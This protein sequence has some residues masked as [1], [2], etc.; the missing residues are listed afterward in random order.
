VNFQGCL[1]RSYPGQFQTLLDTGNG[2]YRRIKG[3]DF[4]PPLG[5]FKQELT[6]ELIRQ[7]VLQEESSALNFLRTGY[8]T[9]TWW[10]DE[11]PDADDA[12]RT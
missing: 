3:N 8:K 2:R 10:E 5:Q 11:R 6:D 1:F 9:T 7:G 12:W 4:R